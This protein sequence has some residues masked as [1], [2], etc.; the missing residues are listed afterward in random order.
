[1]N[2]EDIIALE[3]KYV[4]HT[5]GRQPLALSKGNGALVWDV[6]GKKYIDCFAG[7]A[8]NNVGHAHPKVV[9]AIC[10]QAKKMLHCSNIYYTEEQVVLAKLLCE[11]S[12]Y[13]KVF[14]CNS[15][16][17]ANEGAV[18]LARKYTKKGNVICMDNSFHGR[19]LAMVAA[20]GQHK[21]KKGIEPIPQGFKHTPYGDVDAVA[22]KIDD[23]TAGVLVE[24]IQ[25][26]GGVVVPPKNYLKELKEL[27]ED[28]DIL[29]MVDEVQTGFGR[30]GNMFASEIFGVN[31]DITTIA[32]GLGGGFPIGGIL[33]RE[34]I[35]DAF[36]AGDHGTTFGGNPLAC[37]AA[38][39][40]IEAIM[41]ENL[42]D[43]AKKQGKYFKDKLMQLKKKYGIIE[44]VRGY[45]L[46]IGMELNIKCGDIVNKVADKGVLINCTADKV[47]RFAPPLLIE[48]D[49]IDV[50]LDVLD[51]V[52]EK[53]S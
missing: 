48:K 4:M 49:Q 1:M 26:E 24:P 38:K 47:L 2:T 14:F 35:A 52:L 39:A 9:D 10:N 41:E 27:C 32:K 28:K 43:N 15:G 51:E 3:K 5:Y 29:F 33:A 20:T 23:N 30:T 6:D 11:I 22:E 16:A 53:V 17:E 7:L 34:E 25:G 40:S 12:S 50:T 13:D 8:V 46:L 18:K 21:Y 42:T 37:A 19:T 45:G 44:D 36:E 31:A